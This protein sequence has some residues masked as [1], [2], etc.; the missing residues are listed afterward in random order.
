MQSRFFDAW[1]LTMAA[2][3][4]M[5][6][7]AAARSAFGLFVSPVNTA[8]GAGL[9]TI[10]RADALSQLGWELAQPLVGAAS[11][12]YGTAWLKTGA[13]AVL[14]GPCPEPV[15]LAM[16]DGRV[17]AIRAIVADDRDRVA[18]FVRELT[19]QSRRR[20]FFSAIRELSAAMLDRLTHPDPARER[21]LVA[22]TGAGPNRRI[23]AIAQVV[24]TDGGEDCEFALVVADDLQGRGLG[25][26]M[27]DVVIEAARTAG[28][29]EVVGEVLRDNRAMLALARRAGFEARSS[30]DPTLTRI[31]RLVGIRSSAPGLGRRPLQAGGAAI[32]A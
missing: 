11:A 10:S 31:G 29:R 18:A 17:I 13:A 14:R 5:A 16:P 3:V 23:V 7:T 22:I 24:P 4:L 30:K 15:T 25:I 28:Y 6:I 12:C 27:L 20:R 2:A 9:A 32:A 21:V 26:R 8:T 19:P 1:A